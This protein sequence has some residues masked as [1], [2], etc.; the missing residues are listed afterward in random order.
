MDGGDRVLGYEGD[1]Y[2][3][4]GLGERLQVEGY[5]ESGLDGVFG[6]DC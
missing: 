4:A 3:G 5:D 6:H 2:P 1:D